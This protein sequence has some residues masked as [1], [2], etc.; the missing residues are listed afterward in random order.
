MPL[1][2]SIFLGILCCIWLAFTVWTI[3][4][5][6]L[7]APSDKPFLRLGVFGF[8]PPTWA[9]VVFVCARSLSEYRP[10]KPVLLAAAILG[11]VLLPFFLWAGFL[12]GKGMNAFYP[13]RRKK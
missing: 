4:W 9:F 5:I 12:W 1:A 13:D 6:T 11:F 3:R 7:R 8:G 2:Q 10:D